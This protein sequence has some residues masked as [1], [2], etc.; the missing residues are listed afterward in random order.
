MLLLPSL[1][2]S[3]F[4]GIITYIN[5]EKPDLDMIDHI[6]PILTFAIEKLATMETGILFL[7]KSK[8]TLNINDIKSGKYQTM[9]TNLYEAYTSGRLLDYISYAIREAMSINTTND[10][11]LLSLGF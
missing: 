9:P 1:D 2:T 5:R 6:L 10:P 3:G 7:S 4:K 8:L 11:K